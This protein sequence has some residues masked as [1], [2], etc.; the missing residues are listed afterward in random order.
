[1]KPRFSSAFKNQ[2]N[3]VPS[4][5]DSKGPPPLHS[6]ERGSKRTLYFGSSVARDQW[7][8]IA[9][10][11]ERERQKQG[12]GKD[13]SRFLALD[14]GNKLLPTFQKALSDR[15]QRIPNRASLFERRKSLYNASAREGEKNIP[16]MD[17][18]DELRLWNGTELHWARRQCYWSFALLKHA[19]T[20][21]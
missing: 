21:T 9:E 10:E 15:F 4:R 17:F 14:R 12:L 11:L 18:R 6:R 1:M 8:W 2:E 5:V 3:I 20:C 16:G 13:I 7:E 19:R